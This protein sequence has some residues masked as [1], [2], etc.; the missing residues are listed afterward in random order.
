[1]ETNQDQ[2]S[3]KQWQTQKSPSEDNDKGSFPVFLAELS[4]ALLQPQ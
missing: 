2:S 1:M 4:Y 3:C